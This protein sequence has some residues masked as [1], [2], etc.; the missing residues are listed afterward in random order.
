MVFPPLS[1]L[2][3]PF[4]P[5]SEQNVLKRAAEPPFLARAR[6]SVSL[7]RSACG[8]SARGFTT[9]AFG[10]RV[11]RAVLPPPGASGRGPYPGPCGPRSWKLLNRVPFPRG[12]GTR[13]S[14]LVP[15]ADAALVRG[16]GGLL[17]AWQDARLINCPGSGSERPRLT[18]LPPPGGV[19]YLCFG[20]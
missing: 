19:H 14:L 13:T 15:P 6:G 10:V 18:A 17:Q 20:Y 11:P 8:G 16:L 2:C 3:P 4:F 1:S 5:P 12:T 7:W 9:G